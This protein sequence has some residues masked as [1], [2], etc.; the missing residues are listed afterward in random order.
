L[1]E[2]KK[3]AFRL[4]VEAEEQH[5]HWLLANVYRL[6]SQLALVELNAQSAIK[7]LEKTQKI[8]D[9]INNE[10]LKKT[11]KE[12]Q[13]KLDKQLGMLNDL[14]KQKAPINETIKLVSL[15]ST[16]KNIKQETVLEDRDESGQIIEYRKLFTLKI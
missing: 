11:I 8:A 13:E 16:V 9:E 14:Q 6:Q 15:E 4:E 12:D 1:E 2:V 10:I 7:L 5:Y 3:Q